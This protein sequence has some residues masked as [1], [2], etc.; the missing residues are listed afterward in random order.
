MTFNT[1]K[2]N[3][4]LSNLEPK[5]KEFEKCLQQWQHRKLTLMGKIVVI[6]NYALPK[7]IYPLT[8]L[9][10][11]PKD[12]INR[13]E[14]SMYNFLWDGKPDKIKRETITQDY[15][16]GGL[17]MIDI[18]TFI[19]SLKA[20]WV[21]RLAQTENNKLLKTVYEKDLNQFGGDILFESSLSKEDIIRHFSKKPF[22]RDVLLAWNNLTSKTVIYNYG[23]EVI[24]NNSN[25][26]VDDKTIFFK[27]W[28]QSG[29]KYVKDMFDNDRQS[30]YTFAA[31]KEKFDLPSSDF[32][33][34]LSILNS[35]P[36][37]WK[38]SLK[39][40]DKNI[41]PDEKFIQM[42]KQDKLTNS[43]I[44]KIFMQKQEIK[45]SK[46]QQKWNETFL[47][48]NL[49]W[50]A[51]FLAAQKSTIDIKLRNFQ[52]KHLM[53]IIPT[54]QFLTKCHKTSS[55]LCDFCNME[56]E[57]LSHLFWECIYVQEFWTSLRNF[58]NHIHMNID[59]TLKTAT[60]GLCHQTKNKTQQAKNFI[61]F[62]AKYFI[63][64]SKQRKNKPNFNQ[65]RPFISS[66]IYIEKE[67]AL[68]NDKLDLFEEKWNTFIQSLN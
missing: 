39:N 49:N 60:F 1:N 21:K 25:I 18:E 2:R 29:I 10:N 16:H 11:P 63:F 67:I 66:K 34:Y 27:N 48:S 33:K 12:T 23:N 61:I 17:K 58:L 55:T 53:R 31:L 32:L 64:L 37:A 41:P 68:S 40:E 4:F 24:W 28:Q 43:I 59:I 45:T 30:F 46:P 19:W 51:I 50:K 5:I 56:I 44:Y 13:L 65:F 9:P 35:L 36:N 22:L 47:N 8:S 62:Q 14:K 54:N 3:I 26:R 7:L 15:D 42:L 52:Y 57:T 20:G 38:R 6:K